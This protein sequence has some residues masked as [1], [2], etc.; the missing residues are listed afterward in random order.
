MHCK[1]CDATMK[2]KIDPRDE[3]CLECLMEAWGC[4]GI[5][6]PE[7]QEDALLVLC[8]TSND[9]LSL[10]VVDVEV[11]LDSELSEEA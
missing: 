11:S 4:A 5:K 6:N 1:A 8:G 7:M 10:E 2:A 9:L 3:L